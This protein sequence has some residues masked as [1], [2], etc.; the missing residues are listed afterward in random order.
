MKSCDNCGNDLEPLTDYCGDL[1]CPE[2]L[3][4]VLNWYE[5]KNPEN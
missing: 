2:C 5:K 4:A 3:D 1:L